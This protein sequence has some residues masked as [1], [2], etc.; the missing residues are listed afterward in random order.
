MYSDIKPKYQKVD[1]YSV[2]DLIVDKHIILVTSTQ[3]SWISQMSLLKIFLRII[4]EIIRNLL[5]FN[6]LST[7]L[8]YNQEI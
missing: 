2:S 7:K 8:F 5:Y 6:E 4:P 1:Y 3:I